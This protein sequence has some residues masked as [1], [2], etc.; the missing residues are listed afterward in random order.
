MVTRKKSFPV[1]MRKPIQ[2]RFKKTRCF[3]SCYLSQESLSPRV[4]LQ[5]DVRV[6]A[7][8]NIVCH[9]Q[10]TTTR[11]NPSRRNGISLWWLYLFPKLVRISLIKQNLSI[12][13]VATSP[14]RPVP[15]SFGFW[16]FKLLFILIG[17]WPFGL[18]PRWTSRK[19]R[20]N[21]VSPI[22][23]LPFAQAT[24]VGRFAK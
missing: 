7:N 6:G 13:K 2:M 20:C 21:S 18:R 22:I 8:N 17:R 10:T 4:N 19:L 23:K 16:V 5:V 12:R 14:S 11:A 24:W 1:N 15:L 9:C 3:K